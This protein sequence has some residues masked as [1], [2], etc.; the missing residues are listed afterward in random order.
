MY[1]K[2]T[3]WTY[4]QILLTWS[5]VYH[6]KST[7]LHV[8]AHQFGD[9]FAHNYTLLAVTLSSCRDNGEYMSLDDPW[10]NFQML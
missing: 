5:Q 3:I 4:R 8:H 1:R 9:P 2:L 7:V 10:Q 6:D